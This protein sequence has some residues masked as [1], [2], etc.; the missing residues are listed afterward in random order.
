MNEN[1]KIPFYVKASL[2]LIGGFILISMLFIAQHI[3]IPIIYSIIIAILLSPLVDFFVLKKIN[4]IVAIATSLAL[5]SVISIVFIGL[6]GSQLS[7]FAESFPKLLDNFDETLKRSVIW[8]AD[9]FNI[10]VRKCNVFINDTK[11]EI[12]NYSKSLIGSTLTTIASGL[13]VIV[14]VPVY[15]FMILFYKP[16]LLDFI[17]RVF[18]INHIKEV[19]EILHSTKTIIQRYLVAL[20]FEAAIIATLNSIGLLAIGVDYAILLGI[21]G[22]ILNIIPYIGGIIAVALPMIIT[23]STKSSSTDT[24]LVLMLYVFI[25]FIDNHYVIPK[26]VASKVKI[27][28]FISIIVVLAGG[29]LWGIPG[30]FLSIPLT[31]II[32]VIFDRIDSLKPWGFLLGDTMPPIAVFKIKLINIK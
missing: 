29:A 24:L 7:M 26:V 9:Y 8:A 21:I 17:R 10:S 16:L 2:I 32:K 30:M 31:A 27:N 11:T 18:S 5:V 6:L 4:R 13:V 3:I 28:G 1:F 15:V 19:N 12:L 23:F 20:L 22:A 14:L 25:Q